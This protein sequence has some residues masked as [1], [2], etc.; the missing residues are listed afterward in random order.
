MEVIVEKILCKDTHIKF[1]GVHCWLYLLYRGAG[2]SILFTS[3]AKILVENHPPDVHLPWCLSTVQ[4]HHKVLN[5]INRCRLTEIPSADDLKLD[6]KY[7]LSSFKK[8]VPTSGV[9]GVT[10]CFQ[11]SDHRMME[12]IS[13]IHFSKYSPQSV[14]LSRSS[15]SHSLSKSKL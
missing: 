12:I 1:K 11:L 6:S 5:F 14:F 2:F 4:S 8:W 13:N 9:T 7:L 15:F 10:C 3:Y